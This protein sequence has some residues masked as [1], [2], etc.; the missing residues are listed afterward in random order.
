MALP[1]AN[2]T[3]IPNNEPD[4]VP[5]LWNVRYVEIDDNFEYLEVQRSSHATTISNLSGEIITA[6]A[7][8]ANLDTRLDGIDSAL[9]LVSPE[10][11]Q[12]IGTGVMFALDQAALA[13]QG[14]ELLRTQQQ[15]EGNAELTNRGV[16]KGCALS[17]SGT[18]ARNVSITPGVAFMSGR[19]WIVP[20]EIN[21]SSVPSNPGVN[22]ETVFAYLYYDA[23]TDQMRVSITPIGSSIPAYG[24]HIY[25]ITIPAGNTDETD[26]FLASVSLTSVRRLEPDYPSILS[27]PQ[28][29]SVGIQTLS[30]SDYRVDFDIVSADG[31][32]V[33]RDHV[34]ILSRATNGFLLQLA[35]SADNVHIRWRAS[36][37]DN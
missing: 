5:G 7:G 11:Q 8:K 27:S 36:K 21:A 6:R 29:H 25:T 24:I 10:G 2:I 17:K 20:E 16:V 34:R 3:Q 13:V 9:A 32:P 12:A 35:T 33:D 19:Q 30:A 22:S 18:S 1:H 37:L 28:T 4:A 31:E 26:Q 15:Q 23:P 14:V